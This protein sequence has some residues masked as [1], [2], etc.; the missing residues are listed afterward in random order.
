MTT[1]VDQ[2][3][4][5]TLSCDLP[6]H[7][8]D[9]K[10]AKVLDELQEEFNIREL[11]I[12]HYSVEGDGVMSP[13]TEYEFMVTM[14]DWDLLLSIMN[15]HESVTIG[16]AGVTAAHASLKTP[17]SDMGSR[18]EPSAE[19]T[20]DLGWETMRFSATPEDDQIEY[21]VKLYQF[22]KK[23]EKLATYL[24]FSA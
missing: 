19:S 11:T 3:L 4:L 21:I 14:H 1:F 24:I 2:L 7:H 22:M 9:P 12:T 16:F 13:F 10:I 15:Y 8:S 18:M 6:I 20:I 23:T 5:Q 17:R